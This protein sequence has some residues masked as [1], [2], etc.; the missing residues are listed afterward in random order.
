MN[1]ERS[2]AIMELIFRAIDEVNQLLP[3]ERR[4]GKTHATI[5]SNKSEQGSLDSLG[6]VN[7]I[8]ALEQLINEEMG[9][10]VSLAD[11][12]IISEEH[13]PFHTVSILADNI[14]G[15]LMDHQAGS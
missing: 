5:L 8:V 1:T 3:S 10:S 7:F 9:V 12:L 15:L 11:D 6:M 4:L 14:D 2:K 13:N